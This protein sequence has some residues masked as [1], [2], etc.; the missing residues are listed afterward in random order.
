MNAAGRRPL[1]A[2]IHHVSLLVAD[3]GPELI[4]A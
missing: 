2:D 1:V 3:T 4:G